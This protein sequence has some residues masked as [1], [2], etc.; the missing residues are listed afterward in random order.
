MDTQS[1]MKQ[2]KGWEHPGMRAVNARHG[3]GENQFGVTLSNLRDL[4][5]TIKRD[6]ELA[7]ELWAT[8]NIDAMNLATLIMDP[9]QLTQAEVEK[10]AKD[11]SYFTTTDWFIKNVVK[12]LPFKG[13]LC[14]KWSRAEQEYLG[15]AGWALMAG[16]LEENDPEELLDTIEKRMKAAPF[17]TQETM[18]YCLVKIG[19][20]YPKLR[21]RAIAI[22]NKLEVLKDYPVPKGCTSPFAPIW[23][24][25][26]LEHQR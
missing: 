15:R 20:D 6:H 17:R 11:L 2:L 12:A 7:L 16:H 13:E 19:V 4:A 24:A 10:L 21:T 23:I 26:L 8:G 14:K 22:G 3:A 1:V 9:K 5:K 25:Y 18:N